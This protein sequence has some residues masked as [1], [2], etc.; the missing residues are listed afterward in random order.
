ML[1]RGHLSL[2]DN[3]FS[4]FGRHPKGLG[5]LILSQYKLAEQHNEAL[6]AAFQAAFDVDRLASH[7]ATPAYLAGTSSII[8]LL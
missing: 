3:V 2:L 7:L 5:F 4:A 1:R 8:Q 6:R